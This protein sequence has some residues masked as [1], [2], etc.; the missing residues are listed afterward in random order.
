MAGRESNHS[1]QLYLVNPAPA[2]ERIEFSFITPRALPVL[3]GGHAE[4]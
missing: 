3:A 1:F 2:A 4:C